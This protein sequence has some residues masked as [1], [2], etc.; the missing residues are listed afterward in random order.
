MPLTIRLTQTIERPVSDV[1]RF[2]A[3]EH[4]RNHPRWDP[5][6]HLEQ[7][8]DG[9][10]GVGTL[11][12]RRVTRGDTP[13]EGEMRVV[14]YE[15]NKVFGTIIK[16]G[17]A[18]IRGQATFESETEGHTTLTMSAEFADMDES[19]EDLISGMMQRSL[20]NIKMLVESE[21]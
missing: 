13:V 17:P 12:R 20:D 1:F 15:K 2:V 18:E 21:T 4:V 16:D 19:Q 10:I 3:D 5:D 6:M 11:I 8:T 9:P 14:E 7:V